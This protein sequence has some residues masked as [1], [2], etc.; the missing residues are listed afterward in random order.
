MRNGQIWKANADGGQPE[1]LTERTGGAGSPAESA[2][3]KSLYFRMRG[4]SV[5]RVPVTGGEAEE[6][7][8]ADGPII[9][10]PQ[11]AKNGIYYLTFDRFERAMA[12]FFYDFA[13]KK[14]APVYR[15]R[16]RDFSFSGSFAVSPDEKSVLFS[17]VDQSQT[18]LMLVENFQ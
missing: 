5:W 4:A 1:Q 10:D 8:G 15:M 9:G 11:P 18:N 17:R 14:Q 3:G 13:A 2:D 12:V 16:S 6:V 7:F